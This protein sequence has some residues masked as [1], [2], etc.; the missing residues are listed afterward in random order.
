MRHNY[1]L[2]GSIESVRAI[3][4]TI[5]ATKKYTKGVF[6]KPVQHP[7]QGEDFPSK[8]LTEYY[9]VYPTI[10]VGWDMPAGTAL[11][12]LWGEKASGEKVPHIDVFFRYDYRNNKASV[13]IKNGINPTKLLEQ[14]I[15]S[16]KETLSKLSK[17]DGK[18]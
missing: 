12:W 15:P 6:R 7:I 9:E 16:F 2:V 17:N 8:V 10:E 14:Y 13:I 1:E 4:D 3:E 11:D 5:R 18:P